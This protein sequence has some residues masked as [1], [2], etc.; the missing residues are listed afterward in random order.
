MHENVRNEFSSNAV[1]H[2]ITT[3]EQSNSVVVWVHFERK[4]ECDLD[5]K[6]NLK[7]QT[8]LWW[9]YEVIWYAKKHLIFV[10]ILL[11]L[12]QTVDTEVHIVIF[13]C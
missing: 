4:C 6:K 1:M 12:P 13:C 5:Q 10:L 11:L 7:M 3:H 8:K 9:E 2:V